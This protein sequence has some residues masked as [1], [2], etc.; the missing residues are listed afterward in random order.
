MIMLSKNN[1]SQKMVAT[2]ERQSHFGIRKLTIGTVSVL[3]GTTLWVGT[4]TKEVHA[5]TN[6]EGDQE[7]KSN[8]QVVDTE[9]A[10]KVVVVSKNDSANT[11]QTKV[12]HQAQSQTITQPK[13]KVETQVNKDTQPSNTT[14][15]NTNSNP[16]KTQAVSSTASVPASSQSKASVSPK[17]S[18]T[19]AAPAANNKQSQPV[20][21]SV[22]TPT[23]Q[24]NTT[25]SQKANTTLKQDATINTKNLTQTQPVAKT[26][27]ISA[28]SGNLGKTTKKENSQNYNL[29]Q[30]A[31]KGTNVKLDNLNSELAKLALD[32]KLVATPDEEVD[33]NNKN[34]QTKTKNDYQTVTDWSGVQNAIN[35]DAKGVNIQGTIYANGNLNLGYGQTFT[36]NGVNGASLNLGSGTLTATGNVTFANMNITSLSQNGAV[37]SSQG[38]QVTFDNVKSSGASLYI[39]SGDVHI[40]GN[41]TTSVD[42]GAP[43]ATSSQITNQIGNSW[44]GI[45]QN[46][47][48]NAN[49]VASNV[50]VDENANLTVNRQ[51]DGDGIVVTAGNNQSQMGHVKV[52]NNAT[53]TV[54]LKNGN[55]PDL[56]ASESQFSIG[57]ANTA[58]RAY[59]N[60]SFTT[61][62]GATVNL[63]VGHGRGI[64][65]EEPVGGNT[66]IYGAYNMNN[67][68][69]DRTVTRSGNNQNEFKLGDFT[70]FNLYGR[71]GVL[72]GDNAQ[73]VTGEHSILKFRN[74]GNGVAIDVDA[75]ARVEISPHSVVDLQSNGKDMA[76]IWNGGNY[77][78]LGENA[79]MVVDH[80]ATFKYHLTNAWKNGSPNYVD[81]FNIVSVKNSS[82]P[83][84][85]IGNNAVFDGQSD[86]RNIFGEIVSFSYNDA[87]TGTA[88]N[89]EGAKYVNFQKNSVTTPGA[90]QNVVPMDPEGKHTGNLFYSWPHNL[91]N[92]G[93]NTYNAYKWMDED[94]SA[95]TFNDKD[96]DAFKQSIRDLNNSSSE[97]WKGV[98][99]LTLAYNMHRSHLEDIT[100]NSQVGVKHGWLAGNS[101]GYGFDPE[102]SQRVA[103]IATN[104][105][106]EDDVVTNDDHAMKVIV[107]YD[108]SL[109]PGE[110][111]VL[112]KG[113]PGRTIT[114]TRTYY[115]VNVSNPD[116]PIRTVDT[117]KGD[118]GHQLITKEVTPSVPEIIAIGPQTATINYVN[119]KGQPIDD[120]NQPIVGT[121]T[122]S[123]VETNQDGDVIF[124]AHGIP[125]A[126][127][128]NYNQAPD[129]AK[130]EAAGYPT[131]V[132]N[133]W[134]TKP[135][136]YNIDGLTKD[137]I[138]QAAEKGAQLNVPGPTFKVVLK[139]A[140]EKHNVTVVF[141]D[142]TTN[143]TIPNVGG[144]T[145][146]YDPE[147]PLTDTKYTPTDYDNN[148]K[149]L[150]DQGYVPDYPDK[151]VPPL[152]IAIPSKN[153]NIV[154]NMKHG[155]QPVN[156]TNP[157][158]PG[159]PINPN[160]PNGPKYP[161]GTTVTDL[162]KTITR[163]IKYEGAGDLTPKDQ[164]QSVAFQAQGY[165]DKVTGKW[166]TEDGQ[167]AE[168]LTWTPASGSLDEI[169]AVSIK[170]YHVTK[171]EANSN[172]QDV[173][174]ANVQNNGTVNEITVNYNSNNINVVITYA[175][176][177][178]PTPETGSVTVT[179]YDDTDNT[180]IPDVG[181]QSGTKDVGTPI[182]YN[183]D[184]T[185]KD[186]ENKGYKLVPGQDINIPKDIT[187]GNH[188]IIIHMVHGMSPVNPDHP[189]K[190]VS[191]SEY[192][193]D[194]TATVHYEGAGSA[195]PADNVQHA[196]WTRTVT[197]DDVTQKVV[198]NGQYTTDW[199]ANKEDYDLVKT[200]VVQGYYADKAEIPALKVTMENLRNV[201]TYAPN[202]KIIPV[203][204]DGNPI[205]D[206][207]T[208]HFPTNP[209]NPTTTTDG[210]VPNVPDYKPESG[211][212]GDPVKPGN[213]PGDDVKVPYVKTPDVITAEGKVTYYDETAKK[214]LS[215]VDLKG[216]VGEKIS[217][218]TTATITNYENQ[219]YQ[220][221]N[222][223]FKNGEETFSRDASANNFRVNFVHGTQTVTPDKPGEPGQPINPNDPN[224][225]KWPDDTDKD[226]LD[227]AGKQTIH[228]EGAGE[229]TPKDNVETTNFTR[230]KTVDKVTGDVISETD[231]TPKEHDFN[232]VKTPVVEGYHANEAEAGGFKS[233]PN[234][235]TKT[236]TVTYSPNGKI[237]PVT[238]DGTPIPNVPNPPYITNPTNPTGVTPN[239]PVPTIPA[240]TPDKSTITPENPGKDTPVIYH[241]NETPT[242]ETGSVTVTYHDDTT[243]TTIPGVGYQSGT[244]DVNTPVDYNPD[245][246]IKDLE[247]K[248]Y[249][250]VPGQ[251]IN[252]PK[253]I[254]KGAHDIVIHMVHGTTTVTPDKPGDPGQPINPN[255]PNGPKW[256]DDTGK[257][258][259]EKD[260][261]QTIHY[262]GAG[263]N[264]PKD[265][266]QTTTFTRT[267]TVD[268][269]TGKI[270]SETDWTPS[271]HTFGTVK[272]PVI[273]GYHANKAEAGGFKSTPNDPNTTI[274]VTY[275]PNGKIV[276]VTP[277]GTP[278]PN[279]P[280]PPYTTNP[281]NPTGVTPNEPVPTIP[282]YTPEKN[283]IT[284]ENP[285]KDTPVIYHKNETPTP[286]TGSVT[287]TFH[288]DTTNSTIPGVG[289]QSG[290][291]DVNTPVN[292]NPDPTI[293]DLENKGYKL[294]PGQDINV[295][296]EITKG[297]HDIVIHMV[298]GTT[299]VTPNKPGEPGQPINPNDPNGPKWPNNTGKNSLEKDGKQTIH[300]EGAGNETPK[301]NVQTT[302]FTRTA[303]VDNVTGKVISTTDWTP[304]EHTFGTV[305]TPVIK[306]YHAN[307][308]EAGG[309]KATPNDPTKTYNVTYSPNGKIVP[310]TPD[311]T[312]IPN[313]P[314]PPYTTNP[315]NP[316]GVTPNEPVPTIPGYTPEK[317]TITPE[318]PGKDTP[319]VYHKNETPTPET[320]SVTV[321]YHDDTTN[322]TIPGVGYESGTK[323]VNTPV[324][325]NPDPTI[326]D[327]ENKGYKLVPGQDINVPKEITK[328]AHD[329]TIHMVHGTTTVTPDKPGEPGQPINPNDPNGPK[330]PDDTGKDSLEKTGTQ[331]I[332]YEGAGNETPKDNVQTTTFTRTATV[333]DV[334][335]KVIST[336]D[337][338][339]SEHTFGTVKTPVIKGYHANTAEAGGFKATPNDPTKTYNVT[340]SPNGKIVPVTPDGTPI[341]NVPNPPYTTNPDNPTGVTPN[342]PVPTIPGYTPQTPNVTPTNPGTDTKVVYTPTPTEGS[343]TITVHDQTTDTNLPQY[344]YNSGN[345]ESGSKVTYDWNKVK[346]DLEDKGYQIVT[347]N[348][349]IPSVIGKTAQTITIDVKHGTAPVGP[350]NP[351][352]PGT[353]INPNDPNGPK[354]PAKD[355]YTKNYTS[356]VHFV[357]QDGKELAKPAVQTS[358]WT[359]TLTIDKVTG[360]ILNP[361]TPWTSNKTDYANTPVP[362][363]KG[364]VADPKSKDGYPVSNI[365]PGRKVVQ[366]DISDSVIYHQIGKII[367]V[368][369]SGNPIP[370][371]STP[372][373]QNDPNNPTKVVPNEPVPSVPGYT[374]SQNTI[375]PT[376]PTKDT[377]VVYTPNNP[378]VPVTPDVTTIQAK[379]TIEFVDGDG[380]QLLPSNVQTHTFTLNNGVST[381]SSYTFGTIKVPVIKGYVANLEI[382][383]GKTVTPQDPD[384]KVVV[385]YHKIG[386]IIPVTPD[387]NPIPG[388]T[389][390]QYQNDP[391]NPTKVLPNEPVPNVPGYTPSQNT[392]TPT[393]PTEDTKVVYNKTDNTVRPHPQVVPNN[394]K[395]KKNE[396]VRPHPQVTP[397]KKQ[398]KPQT[399]KVQPIH[400]GGT[401]IVL[402]HGQ[403]ITS[404]G[405]IVT[406]SGQVVGYV[407]NNEPHYIEGISSQT[408]IAEKKAANNEL[409]Q[410]G[411]KDDPTAAILGAAA[412]SIGLIGLAGVKKRHKD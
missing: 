37:S 176:D 329:I 78:G 267:A 19:Q 324:D 320:G 73:F 310:V 230:T 393:S 2:A 100:P 365:L 273:K 75:Q 287:V 373:Y 118:N 48:Y 42:Y 144:N 180:T 201:V 147:T 301:D 169:P 241:K 5:D 216:N 328:G 7:Q 268:N 115:N 114:V 263:E 177:E 56:R 370:G 345:K 140:V 361:D 305:K 123:P 338:T 214:V 205:P 175:P 52:D 135:H 26:P 99:D 184:P 344:G 50:Y 204:K 226:S 363:I 411:E 21:K 9:N 355:N 16:S 406:P 119:T 4:Q 304:N 64:V 58:I 80:D 69:N 91:W 294:V 225:P 217:Y 321:T 164:T 262:E 290:T 138:I 266:V 227:K 94:I 248:G 70:N 90:F 232:V 20:Q 302:S 148:V 185:I 12:P 303:T 299:T 102:F 179:Y 331:T 51:V 166:V 71:D 293:K 332:H 281:T 275:S 128:I 280:N 82:H 308:A 160:D 250:L 258:S 39:G 210:K 203:D 300:Y 221:V 291:K 74:G 187:K 22:E 72:I 269:V 191:P 298:H 339:P 120:N 381:E 336:T 23:S 186:L 384:A 206:A 170:G 231:W 412:A 340:Y 314:N 93:G 159:Q 211:Q 385:V 325:Y 364:Y 239:E 122:A 238:P 311:G 234:D 53:L 60:G 113:T 295:P 354:W 29:T 249:K 195:T 398:T 158:K 259:L 235:P 3:L 254:T 389:T 62:V 256:P 133:E 92:V 27:Q 374:P 44:Q 390:P 54:N 284:P 247:N 391:N 372:Q 357:D 342:E 28:Q 274:T 35:N 224:G 255:D 63:N 319:V 103:L 104:I 152:P 157:G 101:Q 346:T 96:F 41:T 208:P 161:D 229:K 68:Y 334:T 11:A 197:I 297:A 251:D 404:E 117:S 353:P 109:K 34:D 125:T 386:E 174:S 243:N 337:W 367:P 388:A 14:S 348:V 155:I 32:A 139:R 265:N 130:A 326:K 112:Q 141:H 6:D 40:K 124:N 86:Y 383:G 376:S 279:V 395:P 359:R 97:Y 333:D 38:T 209:D 162:S 106:T 270:I 327:L 132:S 65:F 246:T 49:I 59:K 95:D 272:T 190:N 347:P 362:V 292:Y 356:T 296:K 369:P 163:T 285:G 110:T 89:I 143:T 76:G 283:T 233:T 318:D 264:T 382:A 351:H 236:Y 145:G 194:V 222:S 156:P 306:G 192:E 81:N 116:D 286:E 182:N 223:D 45:N 36:I 202:G 350:N 315:D 189:N 237:I 349:Q 15:R 399:P 84:I 173:T 87:P 219:G 127:T 380:V 377:P 215:T 13:Q 218:T 168:G 61:G 330:W 323:D 244:K 401:K 343:L 57:N 131:I 136:K 397:T 307:K 188:D 403:R 149:T 289:Y 394:N 220:F 402:P 282:G 165:L 317:N 126:N 288:D 240:Y 405:L 105:P 107:K 30:A 199:K 111:K 79:Q 178:T 150:E 151:Q 25:Q 121:A 257:N 379:Q 366:K 371:A 1:R 88:V 400:N 335:G 183:P 46:N 154:I 212:P 242:P 47:W 181:Y 171:V 410:T 8:A 137:A 146:D 360:Q 276:P 396:T 10:K 153:Q 392:V 260:G 316:T 33:T 341:P 193:K 245:P 407:Q 18:T 172:G 207:P 375:T 142:T 108:D 134:D 17:T 358:T 24:A 252:V 309:F 196:Q 31:L 352:E 129:L 312:P 278:I 253:E 167:A 228:Y 409:P 322:S 77:I 213:N 277:D 43:H 66:T 83:S 261:K 387:G 408:P 55:Q 98:Q 85:T 271:E 67:W 368:T 200:P 198:E 378:N 313:V